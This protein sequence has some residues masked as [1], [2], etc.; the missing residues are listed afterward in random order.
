MAAPHTTRSRPDARRIVAAIASAPGTP[1]MTQSRPP[2]VDPQT[3][4][5]PPMPHVT[6]LQVTRAHCVPQTT[7]VPLVPSQLADEQITPHVTSW[8]PVVVTAPHGTL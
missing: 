4:L 7:H 8:P 3:T 2:H 5:S 1:A 6:L